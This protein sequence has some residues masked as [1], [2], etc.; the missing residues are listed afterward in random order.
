MPVSTNVGAV[1]V[2]TLGAGVR[3]A[4]AA[5]AAA[6]AATLTLTGDARAD[7]YPVKAITVV[8]PFAAGGPTDSIA[9]LVSEHMSRT[10]G[11]PIV[12]ENQVGAGGTLANDRVAKAAPDGY[13]LLVTHVALPAAPALYGNLKYD[14]RTAFTAIGL[15]NNGPMMILVRRTAPASTVAE[16]IPWMRA[17]ADKLT[18]AHAGVGTAAYLC[19]LQLQKVVGA[20]LTFVPY[21]G[22][23][24]AMNDLVGGQI[25]AI[26]D[27]STNGIPQ[28]AAGTIKAMA[29]TGDTRLPGAP[30]VPTATEAGIPEFDM[31][32]W[33]GFY[34]PRGLPPDVL[35]RLNG[36]LAATLAD[37]AIVEKFEGVGNS[38]FPRAEWTPEAHQKRL[39]AGVDSYI[40]L[41]KASGIA[42][43]DAK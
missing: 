39:L 40:A 34:G 31:T 26:C 1:V 42:A 22:T 24:P 4:S 35:A 13:T 18:V 9:R 11:Q 5:I 19:G 23:G 3:L 29:V 15:I 36:A 10:L 33:H 17:N 30:D 38:T 32:V 41:F 14:T 2:R 7:G 21:R 6:V 25:D 12:V 16:L 20:R 37:K 28:I 8:V 43:Q 27:Q